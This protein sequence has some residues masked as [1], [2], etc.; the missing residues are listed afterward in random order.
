MATVMIPHE[1]W[2][3][4]LNQLH[5]LF[6][7]ELIPSDPAVLCFAINLTSLVGQPIAIMETAQS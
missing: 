6:E 5:P 1:N 3:A 4:H 2:R 7:M